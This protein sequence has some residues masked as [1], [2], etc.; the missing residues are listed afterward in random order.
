VCAQAV[1]VALLICIL[2]HACRGSQPTGKDPRPLESPNFANLVAVQSS[3]ALPDG[4]LLSATV[5]RVVS[6][7]YLVIE[8]TAAK[9]SGELLQWTVQRRMSAFCAVA[10]ESGLD[11]AALIELGPWPAGAKGDPRTVETQRRWANN[12]CSRTLAAGTTAWD[13][14]AVQKFVAL[15]EHIHQ[16]AL[17]ATASTP[18]RHK[19]YVSD[20]GEF[21]ASLQQALLA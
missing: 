15:D 5:P 18:T 1:V 10:L 20:S 6:Q 4:L 2:R 13:T 3:V 7:T 19:Q 9:N 12:W 11:A 17:L 14:V 8:V 16:V 21:D